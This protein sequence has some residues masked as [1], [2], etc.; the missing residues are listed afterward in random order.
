MSL[1]P[2]RQIGRPRF[3]KISGVYLIQA[4]N[5][6][7]V[8]SS[9]DVHRRIKRQK[10]ELLR[11]IHHNRELQTAF[12]LTPDVCG[13]LLEAVRGGRQELVDAEDKW[14]REVRGSGHNIVN[15]FAPADLISA[16]EKRIPLAHRESWKKQISDT[17]TGVYAGEK[18]PF[19]GKKHSEEFIERSRV[20][21]RKH[22][23]TE[24]TKELMRSA[25]KGR[26]IDLDTIEKR[27]VSR[28][29]GGKHYLT[30][31]A[32]VGC[33]DSGREKVRFGSIKEFLA[34]GFCRS[35]L[36]KNMRENTPY[37][38]LYWHKEV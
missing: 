7:Y 9:A 34:A 35:P 4:G 11:G 10:T 30:K 22:I 2:E 3:E 36:Y 21:H 20:E 16:F 19:Y 13:Y 28:T 25:H 38:D 32:F 31:G 27:Q 14:Y 37:R 18:N 6:C 23:A 29:E 24:E 5:A 8:G 15:D 26:K 12:R 17:L 33:D 1:I